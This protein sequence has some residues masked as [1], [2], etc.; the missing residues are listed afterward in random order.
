MEPPKYMAHNRCVLHFHGYTVSRGV[1]SIYP[2]FRQCWMPGANFN[3]Q[4]Y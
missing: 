1:W 4:R 2:A 3:T